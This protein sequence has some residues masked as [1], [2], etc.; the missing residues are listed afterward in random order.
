MQQNTWVPIVP[1]NVFLQ[2]AAIP[3]D[4]TY[5]QYSTHSV[6]ETQ[7]IKN[8]EDYIDSND[9]LIEDSNNPDS[10]SEKNYKPPPVATATTGG[11]PFIKYALKNIL[12]LFGVGTVFIMFVGTICAIAY[13]WTK[14]NQGVSF[15]RQSD[16]E[17]TELVYNAIRYWT[18]N[19][20]S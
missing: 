13:R 11:L 17:T 16:L 4:K 12:W 3:F 10:L 14:A 9:D 5:H 20:E 1:S 8:L 15:G 18:D 7:Q 6:K 2:D 19:L